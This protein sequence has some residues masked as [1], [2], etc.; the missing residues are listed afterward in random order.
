MRENSSLC[1]MW[2]GTLDLKVKK[3]RMICQTTELHGNQSLRKEGDGDTE[4]VRHP[5]NHSAKEG[6]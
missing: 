2:E 1:C 3:H 6:P 4:Q 5:R